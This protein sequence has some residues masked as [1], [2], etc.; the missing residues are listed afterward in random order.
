MK[1]RCSTA[2]TTR[3]T[4]LRPISS[5]DHDRIQRLSNALAYGMVVVNCVKM[6]GHLVPFGG[7][8]ESGL[9]REGGRWGLEEF[10]DLKYV[11]AAWKGGLRGLFSD[12]NML[13]NDLEAIDRARVFHPST[14]LT[15]FARG[16]A[17]SRIVTRGKGISIVDRDGRARDTPTAR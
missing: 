12:Q 6:T 3:P 17:P 10:T 9:R 14:Q 5:R 7:V 16:E 15:Q 13:T 11:C 4:V 2:L 8:K 1:P